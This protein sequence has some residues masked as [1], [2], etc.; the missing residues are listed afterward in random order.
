M[1][2]RT[3]INSQVLVTGATGVV[4]SNLVAR[5]LKLGA[6]VTCFVRDHDETTPLWLSG[7]VLR[8]RIASGRLECYDHIKSAIVE[9]EIDTVFHL[10]AQTIVGAGQ[11]DPRGTFESNVCGTYNLLEA[12][13]LHGEGLVRRIVVASSDK[14]YGESSTLPYTEQTPLAATNPYDVS[15][16]CADL[17]AQSYH[18][19]YALPIA[20]ARCGNI[21]GPGDLN[22]SRIVPG[23][24][25]SLLAGV[26]PVIRS[27]GSPLRD[28]LYID[29]AVNAYLAL[30]TWLD[31]PQ[32][33]QSAERAFNFSS[34]DPIT[35]LEMTERITRATGISTLKPIIE[36]TARGEILH[37]HLDSSRAEKEL[38]WKTLANLD[39]A[40]R[41]TV[42]WYRSYLYRSGAEIELKPES[43][44]VGVAM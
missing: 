2:D 31:E 29:D 39:E 17:I 30:A 14:A 19:S 20:I 9:H 40:L 6:Q 7:S 32:G 21:F 10:G 1:N 8:T 26:A 44:A 18:H 23:T 11:R 25:R 42:G 38:R 28:Y 24:I 15:K 13:R 22:F 35:V 34:N 4:G 36:N 41:E 16:S 33:R 27:D 5:L 12:C 37:Q 43:Q 3:W